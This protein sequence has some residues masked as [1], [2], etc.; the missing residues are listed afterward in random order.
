MEQPTATL[1]LKRG[2]DKPVRNRH[3]WVFSG[4]IGRI[5]GQPAPGDLVAIA[6]H[7]GAPL[8]TAYYNAKS[9]I[10]GR[11]LSWDPDEPIDE[12]FWRGRLQRAMGGRAVMG[13]VAGD[14]QQ[15]TDPSTTAFRLINAEADGLPGLIVDRYGDYLVMQCLTLGIDRRKE[16]LVGLLAELFQPAGI[17]ERSDVDVR[18]KEGLKPV[19]Q[20]LF[21]ETPPAELTIRENGYAFLVDLHHGHKTGFYLDQRDNRDIVGR[22]AL[23][24]GRDVLNVFAYTGAFGVYAAAAGARQITQ[25]DSSTPSLETAERNMQLNGL[26]KESDEYIAGDAFEVLRY[27]REEGRQFDAVILDPPKFAHSQ[28]QLDRATRGYKDLN[29]LA[30]RLLRPNGVLA[31]FSCSGLVS[32]D[33]FQKIVFG[34]AVDAGRDVQIMQTLG[35]AADHPVL[36]SFPESAYLK[37][38]LCRVI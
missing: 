31:T 29:W 19:V 9:Q 10:Q 2:R 37:G 30:L 35:Q 3:P 5:E 21:G 12:L 4:A 32:A 36:L 27:F 24:T 14:R 22:P 18:G 1:I 13:L 28:G 17:L 11:I 25:I 8:A 7:A 15:A 33:L 16:T 26:N 38:L 23:I 20:T 6:D 34:A